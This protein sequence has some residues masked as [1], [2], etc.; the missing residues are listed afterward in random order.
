MVWDVRFPTEK[1]FPKR[2]VR[3][4]EENIFYGTASPDSLDSPGFM[5]RGFL[6]GR[7]PFGLSLCPLACLRL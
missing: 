4:K 3:R 6:I 2:K 7:V 5:A 1:F